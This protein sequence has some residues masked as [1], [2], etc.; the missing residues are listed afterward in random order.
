MVPSSHLGTGS[1]PERAFKSNEYIYMY[2]IF[3]F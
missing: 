2:I 1:N 3:L